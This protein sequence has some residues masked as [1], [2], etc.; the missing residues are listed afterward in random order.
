MG[1]GKK[2]GKTNLIVGGGVV[3]GWETP[4]VILTILPWPIPTCQAAAPAL[5][6]LPCL[7]RPAWLPFVG[8]MLASP[9]G[10]A[11]ETSCRARNGRWHRWAGEGAGIPS[12]P[13][14]GSGCL[15]LLAR[16]ASSCHLISCIHN[17]LGSN[18]LSTQLRK[19]FPFMLLLKI[20][21]YVS[22]ILIRGESRGCWN[23]AQWV[24]CKGGPGD[25]G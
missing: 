16:F 2:S 8:E 13:Q 3:Q 21:A 19:G 17:V 20:E 10:P 4:Q 15:Q 7:T 6:P 5:L 1:E 23:R 12:A 24:E 25:L 18:T 14:K 22:V 9:G 11:S